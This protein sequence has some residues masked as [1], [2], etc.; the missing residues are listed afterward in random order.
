MQCCDQANSPSQSLFLR[1]WTA[2]SLLQ[3]D[4]IEASLE[5]REQILTAGPLALHL[6]WVCGTPLTLRENDYI[7]CFFHYECLEWLYRRSPVLHQM[8][9][10]R[11]DSQA[12]PWG[13]TCRSLCLGDVGAV[14]KLRQVAGV[15]CSRSP[16]STQPVCCWC[17]LDCAVGG[18]HWTCNTLRQLL[19]G[20]LN[21][22]NFNQDCLR[23]LLLIPLQS[24]SLF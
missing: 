22:A 10:L 16:L 15:Q 8:D 2:Y 7:W 20:V 23:I 6:H 21:Q 11:Q 24:S 12:T 18:C 3:E 14:P 13:E 5:N 4:W 1:D 9:V 19:R 17:A